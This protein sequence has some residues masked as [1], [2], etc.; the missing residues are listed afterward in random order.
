[1]AMQKF[2]TPKVPPLRTPLAPALQKE[3]TANP[4]AQAK[5]QWNLP[6]P[7]QMPRTK[8]PAQKRPK[9]NPFFGE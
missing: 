3:L 1:M 2:P 4:L 6:G 9:G 8:A 7:P 5:Q